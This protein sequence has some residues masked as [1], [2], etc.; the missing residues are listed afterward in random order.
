[1]DN[2]WEFTGR[3]TDT[4]LCSNSPAVS[5][6]TMAV[7]TKSSVRVL[8][9]YTTVRKIHVRKTHACEKVAGCAAAFS[10]LSFPSSREHFLLHTVLSP[11]SSP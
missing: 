7:L 2:L 5:L 10:L 8:Y 6:C 9:T 11:S 3:Y 1:M 4:A